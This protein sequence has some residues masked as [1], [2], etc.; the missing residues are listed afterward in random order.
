[1]F[2]KTVCSLRYEGDHVYRHELDHGAAAA[3]GERDPG[4][5]PVADWRLV[6]DWPMEDIDTAEVVDGHVAELHEDAVF[7]VFLEENGFGK[8]QIQNGDDEWS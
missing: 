1:M 4:C 2:N 6:V 7:G 8:K 5:A 3:E